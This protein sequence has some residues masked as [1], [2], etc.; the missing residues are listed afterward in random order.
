M[1]IAGG[2]AAREGEFD[3]WSRFRTHLSP[4]GFR[5]EGF[6]LLVSGIIDSLESGAGRGGQVFENRNRFIVVEFVPYF[7]ILC[8]L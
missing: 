8:F 6:K 4:F 2:A 3:L 7:N 1:H 5:L